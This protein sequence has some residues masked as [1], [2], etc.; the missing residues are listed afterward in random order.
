MKKAFSLAEILVTLMIIGVIAGMTIPAL[1]KDST[2]KATA[3]N[4]KKIYSELNHSFSL[5]LTENYA[6]KLCRTRIFDETSQFENFVKEKLNVAYTC[7]ESEPEKCFGNDN[8]VTSTKSYLLTSG[9]A[10]A[11]GEF[12]TNSCPDDYAIIFIDTNGP[13]P[14]NKGGTDQFMLNVNG[15]GLVQTSNNLNSPNYVE[16]AKETCENSQNDYDAA[17]ACAIHIQSNGWEI[18]Y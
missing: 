16:N 9:I 8:L 17:W 14:P 4:L 1:R 2:N 12:D 13:K 3:T 5:Y 7:D 15:S 10:I 6:S 18:K 11:F